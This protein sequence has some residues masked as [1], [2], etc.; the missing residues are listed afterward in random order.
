MKIFNRIVTVLAAMGLV[1]FSLAQEAVTLPFNYD[2]EENSDGWV[3]LNSS[4]GSN[5]WYRGN[6]AQGNTGYALYISNNNGTSNQYDHDN[7]QVSHAYIPVNFTAA[8]D[9]E[10]KFRVI[11][12]GEVLDDEFYDAL[13]VALL[14]AIPEQDMN[15]T[16]PKMEIAGQ[17]YWTTKTLVFDVKEPGTKY[18]VFSW[19][20]D[21]SG[22]EDAPAIDDVEGIIYLCAPPTGLSS[23]NVTASGCTLSWVASETSGVTNYIVE[24]QEGY[25]GSWVEVGRTASTSMEINGLKQ[26]TRYYFRVKAEIDAQNYS[27]WTDGSFSVVTTYSCPAPTGLT[28]QEQEDGCLFSWTSSASEFEVYSKKS[29]DQDYQ[30]VKVT[31]ATEYLFS[32]WAQSAIYDLKVRAICGEGDTSLYSEYVYATECGVMD[33]PYQEN[34]DLSHWEGQNL[35]CWAIVDHNND[36]V[37]WEVNTDYDGNTCVKYKY[38]TS[39]PG[40]DYL[41]SPKISLSKNSQ[42]S[43]KVNTVSASY[44]EKFAILLST[45]TK[46]VD[47]F[48]EVLVVEKEIVSNE[49]VVELVDLSSYTGQEVYIAI[50]VCSDANQYGL[51]VDDFAIVTCPAPGGLRL[52]EKTDAL[53]SSSAWIDLDVP[54]A[55]SVVLEYK[56]SAD[57]SWAVVDNPSSSF[58][59]QLNGLSANT[60]YLVRAKTICGPGEESFYSAEFSF[61]TPCDALPFPYIE[62]FNQ[63]SEGQMPS[64]W[65]LSDQSGVAWQIGSDYSSYFFQYEGSNMQHCNA[66]SPVIDLSTAEVSRLQLEMEYAHPY[67][68]SG[69]HVFSMSISTDGGLVWT[70]VDHAFT[71]TAQTEVVI[72][73]ADYVSQDATRLQ[74]RLEGKGN[75]NAYGGFKVYYINIVHAP[76]CFPPTHVQVSELTA[77]SATIRWNT[78]ENGTPA[79]YQLVYQKEGDDTSIDTLY[80]EGTGTE[81][82]VTGLEQSTSYVLRLSTIC[83]E[84]PSSDTVFYVRTPVSCPSVDDLKLSEV[85]VDR[86]VISWNYATSAAFE[87]EFKAVTD[88][89]WTPVSDVVDNSVTFEGLSAN[90][91]Y[92]ARVRV[93]CEADDM[94]VWSEISFN[95]A[96][97]AIE[98]P[99]EE[100]FE[101]PFV[102]NVPACWSY[103]KVSGEEDKAQWGRWAPGKEG[104]YAM[105]FNAYDLRD[106]YT[107]SAVSPLIRFEEDALYTLDFWI[108]RNAGCT[109]PN[110]GV[111]VFMSRNHDTVGAE[112]VA[113]IHSNHSLSPVV[114]ETTED[115]WYHYS[116]ELPYVSEEAYIIFYGISEWGYDIMIDAVKVEA[117]KE[118]DIKVTDITQFNPMV[119]R[120]NAP[121]RIEL[122]NEGVGDYVGDLTVSYQLEDDAVVTETVHFTEE[123]PLYSNTPYRYDFQKGITSSEK[124]ELELRAWY[125]MGSGSDMVSDTIRTT[126]V[127]YEAMELPYSTK[128]DG[129]ASGDKYGYALNHNGDGSIWGMTSSLE[130]ISNP[131]MASDD[132]YVVAGTNLVEGEISLRLDFGVE[133]PDNKETLTV[134]LEKPE[135]KTDTLEVFENI[136]FTRDT[137]EVSFR[138]DVAGTGYI[139]FHVEGEPA[140]S[141]LNIYGLELT[142]SRVFDNREASICEGEVYPFG[143]EELSQSGIYVDTTQGVDVDTVV[144]LTLTVNPSYAISLDTAICQGQTI[145]FGGEVYSEAGTYTKEY[146]TV[147]G[148]DSIYTLTLAIK[149]IAAAPVIT[150][151]DGPDEVVLV[152]TTS[153][154]IVQWYNEDGTIDGATE[155]EYKVETNGIY[156]ATATNECGESEPSNKIEVKLTSIEGNQAAPVPSLYPNPTRDYIWFKSVEEMVDVDIYTANGRLIK[157]LDDCG[158]QYQLPVHGWVG[159]T[160]IVKIRTGSGLY[161]YKMVINR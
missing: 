80:T 1:G 5:H 107:A 45:T 8:G 105:R 61:T 115:N 9:F 49:P 76:L 46:D 70:P 59:V 77:T 150:R 56:S 69:D 122:T 109:K 24:Q 112:L 128:F 156:H 63:Y 82:S 143:G 154:K 133:T 4:E 99:F 60:T 134:L 152:A 75:S 68:V 54:S 3:F 88:V 41:V 117:L 140:H 116:Y 93:I 85:G 48:T 26:N 146:T 87:V 7:A 96:C 101:N 72:P 106:G 34:F 42:L 39:N 62:N 100:G 94:S 145:D 15:L 151:E 29:A 125:T 127:N 71:Q 148:C 81:L 135:G 159:G 104:G 18:V 13:Q 126:L 103:V 57:E 16:S 65:Q 129:K 108:L 74:V 131:D 83:T 97:E 28:V 153:E 19:K 136:G 123:E 30:M 91:A 124:G 33:L 51:Q 47:A 12:E 31:G 111:K 141:K 102:G 118:T 114:T 110:E 64:C 147:T 2:F 158:M 35:L 10:L 36:G 90:T 149:P 86:A 89:D 52:A 132:S 139:R 37:T 55:G 58:P 14:D 157:H 50:K 40:D 161:T 137:N 11:C 27:Q 138:S 95:T 78:P 98:V 66:I 17:T 113:Y 92:Q 142:L 22:G 6:G 160:Y 25:S 155:K 119:E 121:V 21:G 73:L 79:R 84:E 32:D 130:F 20:N 23:S 120:S 67:L 43:L 44:P 144:T 53:T 38:S